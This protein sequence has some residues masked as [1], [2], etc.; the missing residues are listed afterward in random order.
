MQNE[1]AN[2]SYILKF[3]CEDQILEYMQHA[4]DNTMAYNKHSVCNSYYY[5]IVMTIMYR[6][7]QTIRT[8][9][10]TMIAL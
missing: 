5:L 6:I 3:F 2:N 1:K 10:K 4:Y 9:F 7:P 8:F